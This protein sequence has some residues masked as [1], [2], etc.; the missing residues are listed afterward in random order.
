MGDGI[1]HAFHADKDRI[2]GLEHQEGWGCYLISTDGENAVIRFQG[3]QELH[4]VR[5]SEVSA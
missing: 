5:L 2:D 4:T 1:L 3:R